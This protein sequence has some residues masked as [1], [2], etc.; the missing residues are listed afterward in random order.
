MEL[1]TCENCRIV[2]NIKGLSTDPGEYDPEEDTW[3]NGNV[4]YNQDTKEHQV[5]IK[6]PVCGQRIFI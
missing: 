6:C 2:L 4:A 5:F 1:K 3:S